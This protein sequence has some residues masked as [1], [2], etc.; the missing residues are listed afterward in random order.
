MMKTTNAMGNTKNNF[1]VMS[2][3]FK[4]TKPDI[5]KIEQV[6]SSGI[7]PIETCSPEPRNP[8]FIAILNVDV[9][10]NTLPNKLRN[11]LYT[12]RNPITKNNNFVNFKLRSK[13]NTTEKRKPMRG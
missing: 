13:Y 9:S 2:S 10:S 6:T 3:L 12:R 4:N 8:L 11:T 7:I 1:S 5:G